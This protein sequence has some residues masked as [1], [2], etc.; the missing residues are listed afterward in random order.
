MQLNATE[1]HFASMFGIRFA[2]H[3]LG[4]YIGRRSAEMSPATR[5]GYTSLS[6]ISGPL[7]E[8]RDSQKSSLWH[9]LLVND[10]EDIGVCLLRT[11]NS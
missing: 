9:H 6:S 8:R 2:Q 1:E 10:A 5:F 7:L 11:T 3:P 4:L